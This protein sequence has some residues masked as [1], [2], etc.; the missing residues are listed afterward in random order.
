MVI[1]TARTHLPDGPATYSSTT[2]RP[3]GWAASVAS[4]TAGPPKGRMIWRCPMCVRVC[5]SDARNI[6]C[7]PQK[8]YDL[9]MI[10][11]WACVCVRARVCVYVC[12]CVF[13]SDACIACR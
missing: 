10:D 9:K 2:I 4:A 6:C 11:V 12:V 1:I 8:K 7:S 5:T 3:C 13:M